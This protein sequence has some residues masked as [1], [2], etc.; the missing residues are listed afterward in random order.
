MIF[1]LSDTPLSLSFLNHCPL[2]RPRYRLYCRRSSRDAA[3]SLFSARARALTFASKRGGGANEKC[4]E[5]YEYKGARR[6]IFRPC[7]R[8]RRSAPCFSTLLIQS[9]GRATFEW[10]ISRGVITARDWRDIYA[11]ISTSRLHVFDTGDASQT[12]GKIR[13]LINVSVV[14]VVVVAARDAKSSRG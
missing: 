2:H 7:E 13:P 1:P 5:D 14:V 6:I 10:R 3:S 8:E 12:D 9:R 4:T 11:P